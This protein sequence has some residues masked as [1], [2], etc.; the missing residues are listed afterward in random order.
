MDQLKGDKVLRTV[1]AGM[2]CLEVRA[3]DRKDPGAREHLGSEIFAIRFV[4]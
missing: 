1:H 4:F 3:S 2:P